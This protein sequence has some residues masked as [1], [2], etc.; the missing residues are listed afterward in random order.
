MDGDPFPLSMLLIPLLLLVFSALCSM[1]EAAAVTYNDAEL[2]RLAQDGHK[3]AQRLQSL[4]NPP[5][6]FM[7]STSAIY[8]LFFLLGG[9]FAALPLQ[10]RM[11]GLFLQWFPGIDPA[12][13]VLFSAI[14]LAVCYTALFLVFGRILP[15]ALGG[16]YHKRFAFS[17]S[18]VLSFFCT[19]L[20]PLSALCF[21]LS[22]WLAKLF[23]VDLLNPPDEVT[24]EEIRMMVDAGNETGVIAESQREMIENIFDLN[25]LCAEDVMT[26]RRDVS[27]VEDMDSLSE[28]IDLSIKEGFS[29]IPVYKEDI[30][31]IVGMVAVK[32]LLPLI[33][34]KQK[35][36]EAISDYLRPI[37]YVPESVHCRDLLTQM[38]AKKI[39]M[40]VVVDEYGG[41]A[42]IVTMEDLLESIVGDITDE[43]D[44]EEEADVVSAA[45]GSFSVD[46]SLDLEELEELIPISLPEERDFDT[47]GGLVLDCLGR[48]PEENEHP[49]VKYSGYA[50][51]VMQME[52]RRIA[53]IK[54]RKLPEKK[55]GTDE[56]KGNDQ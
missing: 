34:D 1:A 13:A 15:K 35:R 2:A 3:R 40:A 10:P 17:L 21:L 49:V 38:R 45:D 41:T 47:V 29:R 28:V 7:A 26:H 30:D 50:F 6:R 46:G 5:S 55:A 9:T 53:R 56:K 33:Y 8:L 52:E 16:W 44:D 37:V 43:F 12:A 32:D 20:T 11:R 4:M 18:P 25:D 42:G 24:E 27:A 31:N 14:L 22:K 39:Q 48:F 19:L 23:H 51:R 36:D 54:I